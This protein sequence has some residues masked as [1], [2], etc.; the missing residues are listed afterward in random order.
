MAAKES[1]CHCN[2]AATANHA[3]I[4]PHGRILSKKQ[5]FAAFSAQKIDLNRGRHRT[6]SAPQNSCK[7]T[8]FAT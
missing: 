5:Q 4:P 3:E 6:S 1:D 7:T 8:P 2:S